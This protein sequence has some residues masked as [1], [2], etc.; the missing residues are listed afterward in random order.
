MVGR[1]SIRARTTAAAT[2]A[3]VVGVTAAA[4]A[5]QV[6]LHRSLLTHVDDVADTQIADVAALAKDGRLP[7][8]LASAGDDGSVVHVV[9]R[10]G[11]TVAS[12]AG[13]TRTPPHFRPDGTDTEARTIEGRRISARVVHRGAEEQTVYV[14]TNLEPVDEAMDRLRAALVVV[15]PLLVLF[16]GCTTWVVVRRA[17]QPVDAIRT[18]VTDIS[19]KSLDERVPVPP[20]QDEIA[21]LATTMNAMLDRLQAGA[22]Q[23]RRF[24]ADASHEAQTPLASLRAE[25]EVALAH[26]QATDW[27]TTGAE[28]LTTTRNLERLLRDMLYL[29][30]MDDGA[31][32]TRTLV[33]L[34]DVV[35]EE[36]TAMRLLARVP[37]DATHVSG[38]AVQGRRDDLTR[39]VRNLLD[40]AVRHAESQV[41][42]G[43]TGEGANVEL[44]VSD[45]GPGIPHADRDKVFERFTRL[46]DAR[47]RTSGG[48]GLGLAIARDVVTSHGG[49]IE[50]TDDGVV[51]R[52]PPI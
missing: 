40:N 42:V 50:V 47:A 22:E 19:S 3:A 46:D 41:W 39:V 30:R 13:A 16:V 6:L 38:A 1:R 34:D 25:L 21:R 12:S 49:T 2:F 32:A 26:P 11:H 18:R 33:D 45:D 9:D 23:Q 8:T 37:I 4:V 48:T 15:G 14:S 24:V 52:L 29:A 17:L 35:M 36:V 5:L 10:F 44:L 51:V 43:L 31:P 7:S 20:S 27:P 28:L